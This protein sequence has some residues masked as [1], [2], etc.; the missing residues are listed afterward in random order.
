[1]QSFTCVQG[2]RN[3]NFK[4]YSEEDYFFSIRHLIVLIL[5]CTLFCATDS[6]IMRKI[7]VYRIQLYL[8]VSRG[9]NSVISAIPA[10]LSMIQDL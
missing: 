7:L 4:L 5:Q 8:A 9:R 10:W 3:K 1:M 6:S 2:K